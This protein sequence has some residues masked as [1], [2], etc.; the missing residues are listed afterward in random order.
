METAFAW[1][2]VVRV[3]DANAQFA[4]KNWALRKASGGSQRK[5]CER[6][7][8]DPRT[9]RDR[10]DRALRLV[11]SRLNADSVAVF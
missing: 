7:G 1:L 9:F 11:C 6:K 3:S 8:I 2:L 5:F 10:K 4:L